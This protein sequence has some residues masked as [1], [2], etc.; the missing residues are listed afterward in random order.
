M[1]NGQGAS[2]FASQLSWSL[3]V[4]LMSSWPIRH[5]DTRQLSGPVPGCQDDTGQ[6]CESDVTLSWP[7]TQISGHISHI[8]TPRELLSPDY[9][10]LTAGFL[11]LSPGV[12]LDPAAVSWISLCVTDTFWPS[13]ARVTLVTHVSDLCR[14]HIR[15]WCRLRWSSWAEDNVA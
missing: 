9:P 10:G 15:W 6:H 7:V 11:Q 13:R 3:S 1:I 14:L 5:P 12:S 2:L 4:S 8:S